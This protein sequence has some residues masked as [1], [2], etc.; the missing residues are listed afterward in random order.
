MGPWGLSHLCGCFRLDRKWRPKTC[1][2]R[3]INPTMSE[4]LMFWL[5]FAMVL[6]LLS[7]MNFRSCCTNETRV[8]RLFYLLTLSKE[9][10]RWI[11]EFHIKGSQGKSSNAELQN[12]NNVL[13]NLSRS[14]AKESRKIRKA[15]DCKRSP[16]ALFG[17]RTALS[18]AKTKVASAGTTVHGKNTFCDKI[19]GSK[20][21][22]LVSSVKTPMNPQC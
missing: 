20:H 22:S 12:K 21:V 19:I 10:T 3:K 16:F 6:K 2:S 8:R 1:N 13:R 15:Q 5:S 14:Y 17:R 9:R 11:P 4:E 7:L 18:P